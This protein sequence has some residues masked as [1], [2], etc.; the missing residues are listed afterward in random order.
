MANVII[1]DEDR[2]KREEKILRDFGHNQNS[3]KE[4]KEHAE[5]VAQ[6]TYEVI[7]KQK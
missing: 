5:Y 7:K 4:M 6:K 1:K 3:S 2:R